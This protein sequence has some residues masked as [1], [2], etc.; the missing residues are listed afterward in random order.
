MR[1]KAIFFDRDNTLTYY[2]PEK[3]RWQHETVSSWSGKPLELPYDRMIKCQ[4][5]GVIYYYR[6]GEKKLSAE[7]DRELQRMREIQPT[8]Q[9]SGED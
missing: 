4:L 6:K 7:S 2:N 3:V 9:W 1:Y 8:I 5:Y